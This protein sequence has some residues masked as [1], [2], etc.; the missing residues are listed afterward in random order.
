MMQR[1]RSPTAS[2]LA[3]FLLVL[4]ALFWSG[5]YVVARAAHAS[6]PPMT[7][8]LG[9]WVLA[10]LLLAPWAMPRLGANWPHIKLILPR[11]G[12]LALLGIAG[13]NSLVY[14]GLQTSPATHGVLLNSF[15]PV[16]II[17]LGGLFW[18]QPLHRLQ[19]LGVTVSFLGVMTIVSQG[20]WQR[21]C[22][23][24]FGGGDWYLLAAVLCWAIY[25]LVL[26]AVPVAVDRLALTWLSMV[27]GLLLVVPF[28]VH[29]WLAG[30]YPAMTRA[31]GAALLYVGIFPSVLAYLF[32][33]Y[34][35]ARLGPVVAGSFIHLM[36]VFGSLLAVA[37]LGETFAFYHVLGIGLI[38]TGV[39]F[40]N[41][42]APN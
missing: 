25:T 15:I 39:V 30:L 33:N 18:R 10:V 38:F 7:L 37:F 4:T 24:N 36:P 42:G 5:N 23:L 31:N 3:V 2:S 21:L 17:L 22:A 32:Y 34:G 13:F 8:S 16:L 28:A 35:V 19:L 27:L 14:T 29:E 20:Q 40:S 26:K 9:R 12:V 11:V 41:R 1:F 6:M